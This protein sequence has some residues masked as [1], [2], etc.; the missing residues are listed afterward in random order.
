VRDY[1]DQRL[2][3]YV[4]ALVAC[5]RS[6]FG[7]SEFDEQDIRD[8]LGGDFVILA[9]A[10]GALVGY[11]STNL[12]VSLRQQF[13]KHF[14]DVNGAYFAAGVVSREYQQHGLYSNLNRLR[15]QEVFKRKQEAIF[16]RT[17]NPFVEA[18]IK[19]ALEYAGITPQIN[20]LLVS[21][22]YGHMLTAS[23]PMR[24][25]LSLARH[26]T[27]LDYGAGDAFVLVFDLN[28]S[29]ENNELPLYFSTSW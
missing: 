13:G 27:Q 3:P 19:S 9:H 10:Q 8:H 16:T 28:N 4:P 1:Q 15:V 2:R 12:N 17:Q 29:G 24:C 5:I 11:A 7:Q 20:R 14:P 18:G 23:Q 25:D 26:Y 6:G 21:G 22:C